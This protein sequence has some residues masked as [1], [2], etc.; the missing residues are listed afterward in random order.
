MIRALAFLRALN[1]GGNNRIAMRELAR[2][3]E[4]EGCT[5]VRTYI[6]SGNVVFDAPALGPIP[7]RVTNR[8]RESHGVDS[9]VILRTAEE[10]RAAV[11]ACPYAP[12][13][14]RLHLCFLEGA[15]EPALLD[16]TRSPADRFT[17]TGRDMYIVFGE[18]AGQSK[19]TNAYIDKALGTR[20]TMRNWNTVSAMMV[21]L[22]AS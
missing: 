7:R 15:G 3:F 5:N 20:S 11:K 1:V 13:T 14:P 12:D 2:A 6:Q 17:I 19:L 22:D 16:P 8:L 4:I 18:G 21:L 10:F 9:P